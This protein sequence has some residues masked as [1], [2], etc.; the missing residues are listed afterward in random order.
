[1]LPLPGE[2]QR[3]NG[4]KV[5]L[6]QQQ[7]DMIRNS[8]VSKCGC[9][10]YLRLSSHM[11][12]CVTVLLSDSLLRDP[13]GREAPCC[14]ICVSTECSVSEANVWEMPR[15]YIHLIRDK[16]NELIR[17]FTNLMFFSLF[18]MIYYLFKTK[19][20]LIVL[21]VFPSWFIGWFTALLIVMPILTLCLVIGAFLCFFC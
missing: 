11:T 16:I 17:T 20:Q 2:A 4:K 15:I 18:W 14:V 12:E 5:P 21:G 10:D 19:K 13:R 1:M 6:Q 3:V 8:V 9:I 7:Q